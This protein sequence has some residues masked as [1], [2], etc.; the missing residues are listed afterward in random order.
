MILIRSK[1]QYRNCSCQQE[2]KD[3]AFSIERLSDLSGNQVAVLES[4]SNLV[5]NRS[6]VRGNQI[7]GT[8]G[9]G[10]V[11]GFGEV[12]S[13]IARGSE[14]RV[15]SWSNSGE[16]DEAPFRGS[17]LQSPFGIDSLNISKRDFDSTQDVVHDNAVRG[18]FNRWAPQQQVAGVEQ[19]S[20][21]KTAFEQ[22]A[23]SVLNPAHDQSE[24]QDGTKDN[25]EI[26]SE[27][28]AVFHTTKTLRGN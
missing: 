21:D 4:S 27:A 16:R 5:G 3:N 19:P 2:P 23:T 28:R 18:D 25:G 11:A 26:F 17:D 22:S 7:A 9:A 12:T 8:N 6:G 24:S 1:E 20:R 14:S 10:D 13:V 15:S